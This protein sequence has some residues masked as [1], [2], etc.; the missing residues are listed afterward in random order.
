[1]LF[2]LDTNQVVTYPGT[3]SVTVYQVVEK[4][5]AHAIEDAKKSTLATNAFQKW[6]KDKLA[7]LTVADHM[8]LN[9]GDADKINYVFSH[10]GLTAQ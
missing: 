2:S 1:M 4:D 9:T 8:D 5:P 10:A 6:V 3:S 7:S